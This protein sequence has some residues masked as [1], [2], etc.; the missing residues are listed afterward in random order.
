MLCST[1]VSFCALN[2]T[3]LSKKVTRNVSQTEKTLSGYT[4][5][6]IM[7]DVGQI[8]VSGEQSRRCL[9]LIQI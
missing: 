9:V 5:K 6:L 3:F 8:G 1:L 7:T 4:I 2:I